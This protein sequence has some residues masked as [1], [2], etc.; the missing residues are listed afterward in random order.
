MRLSRAVGMPGKANWDGRHAAASRNER[1]VEMP[2]ADYTTYCE[3]LDRARK[4]R[5]AY[6]AINV[7]SLTTA[8]AV[9]EGLTDPIGA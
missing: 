8:N 3:V 6:P 9:L 2:V 5:F 1:G 4:R 7:T